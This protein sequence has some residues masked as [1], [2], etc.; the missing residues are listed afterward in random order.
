[1]YESIMQADLFEQICGAL[2]GRLFVLTKASQHWQ[3]HVLQHTALW[4]QLV[5]LKDEADMQIAEFCQ[6]AF[7]QC[8]GILAKDIDHAGGRLVERPRQIQ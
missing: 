5:F 7:G 1:M 8:P 2:R 3:Q 4:Q 6:L